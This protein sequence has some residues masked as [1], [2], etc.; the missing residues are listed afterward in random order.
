MFR[1]S[2]GGFV[3]IKGGG[4]CMLQEKIIAAAADSLV[5]VI[6]SNK[7]ASYLGETWTKGVPIEVLPMAHSLV[8]RK[9]TSS[10]GGECVLRMASAKM[11]P[12]VTDNGNFIIDW[13]FPLLRNNSCNLN[14]LTNGSSYTEASKERSCK[15]W[16]EIDIFLH[17]IPGLIETGLFVNMASAVVSSDDDGN[18]EV[19]YA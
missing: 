6:R 1:C 11:G 5:L 9:I 19:L 7:V 13:K 16:A 3:A 10:L 4:G 17:S 14:G 18:C 8:S 2:N 15:D 12:I